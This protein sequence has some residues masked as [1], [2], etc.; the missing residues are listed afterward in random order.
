MECACGLGENTVGVSVALKSAWKRQL[1]V[2]LPLP[3]CDFE[4]PVPNLILAQPCRLK[5]AVQF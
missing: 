4:D 3:V 1:T 2:G 5:E